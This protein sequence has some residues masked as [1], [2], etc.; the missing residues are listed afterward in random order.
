[1]PRPRSPACGIPP[2]RNAVAA[3]FDKTA[4]PYAADVFGRVAESLDDYANAWAAMRTDACRATRVRGEQSEEL[5]DL[6]MQC[7]DHRREELKELVDLF[8]HPDNDLLGRAVQAAQSLTPLERC[9][10][11]AALKAPIPPP[12]GQRRRIE[13]LGRAVA[14]VHAL[15][16]AGRWVD[17]L[18]A[19]KPL[20]AEVRSVGYRPLEAE[21][22]YELGYLYSRNYDDHGAEA[23][24]R[25]AIAAAT[26]SRHDSV[27]AQSTIE[28]I[29]TLGTGEQRFAE[30]ASW[31]D[32]AFAWL[33]R[34]GGDPLEEAKLHAILGAL[35][36]EMT[37]FG[38]AREQHRLALT[39]REK[40]LGPNSLEVAFTL[41]D[42]AAVENLVG[43]FDEAEQLAR[44][45]WA[46]QERVAPHH[47]GSAL[48]MNALGDILYGEGKYEE[49]LSWYRRALS[50]AERDLGADHYFVA[51]SVMH[52]G[53]VDVRLGSFSEAQQMLE[54]GLALQQKIWGDKH[55]QV[56]S[57][58]A[59]LGGLDLQRGNA[60]RARER[61]QRAVDIWSATLGEHHPDRAGGLVGLG[62]S[63]VALSRYA[64]AR[65]LLEQA[66]ATEGGPMA[67][68]ADGESAL[69]R[70]TCATGGDARVAHR[71]M[72]EAAA[73]YTRLGG[74]EAGRG[75]AA[76]AWMQSHC[77]R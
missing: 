24:F 26:E 77:R 7:L 21:A 1:M 39:L 59:A 43:H 25:Q 68:R 19:A 22:L 27:A 58:W 51:I 56:A 16:V 49:A 42:L 50:T 71:L 13:E 36:E 37:R 61:Y 69:A 54:R 3:A 34:Y 23:A 4:K 64:E 29:Q 12:L 40:L 30:A 15:A 66:L 74:V 38:D 45:A 28:L 41:I 8:L 55:E 63:L 53:V 14:R 11:V 70:A 62:A 48:T 17:G 6:R 18:A 9:A 65:P 5:L 60:A 57:A 76:M 33:R 32:L 44:R 73:I 72:S 31:A 52:I 75:R 46:I 2:R 10:N 20:V 67:Q 47:P 35:Y